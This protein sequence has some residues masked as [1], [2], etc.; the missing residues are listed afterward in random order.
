MAGRLVMHLL[1]L[2]GSLSGQLRL[3]ILRMRRSGMRWGPGNAV[4][5]LQLFT[6]P[7]VPKKDQHGG[8][9]HIYNIVDSPFLTSHNFHH[10]LNISIVK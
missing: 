9:F 4:T 3:Y 8:E 1:S 5:A 2:S 6:N 7:T 10:A